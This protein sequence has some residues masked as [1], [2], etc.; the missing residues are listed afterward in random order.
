MLVSV[1]VVC[2]CVCVLGGGGGGGFREKDIKGGH[3]TAYLRLV[4]CA[5]FVLH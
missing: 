1:T 2:V 4:G 5:V 3:K